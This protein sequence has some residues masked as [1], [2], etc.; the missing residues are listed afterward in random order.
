[1]QDESVLTGAPSTTATRA[2]DVGTYAIGRGTL[3]AQNYVLPE[4]EGS[5]TIDPVRLSLTLDD[6]RRAYGSANPELTWRAAGFVL[7]Q[8]E[9]VLTGAPSTTATRASD[10]GTYAI[11]RGTLAA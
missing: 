7:G 9:S 10:V 1:G 11:G 2:S 6:Q 8:D 4:A 5:L 3:A